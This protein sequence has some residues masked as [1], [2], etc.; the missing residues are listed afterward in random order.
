MHFLEWKCMNL[1]K[2]SPK[3]APKVRIDNIPA[4]VQIMAWRRP[5]NKPSS[6]L[7]RVNLL[8][9]ICVTR[10]QWVKTTNLNASRGP[11]L[12]CQYLAYWFRF[13]LIITTHDDVIKRKH[14]PRYW[15]FFFFFW[16]GGGGGGF[17]SQRPVT[18]IF[19]VFFDLRLNKQWSKQSRRRWFEPPS[20]SLWR[21]CNEYCF[22]IRWVHWC[23]SLWHML[24]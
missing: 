13:F 10:P 14:F 21:H 24:F 12:N 6:E 3:F 1:P 15:P 23:V 17:P 19:D 11:W 20:H 2:I 9:H 8:S 16:G 22:Y 18:R 7:M 4:L 5:A